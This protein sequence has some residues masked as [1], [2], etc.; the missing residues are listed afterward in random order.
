MAKATSSRTENNDESSD[1]DLLYVGKRHPEEA[2][3]EDKK[4]ILDLGLNFPEEQRVAV[5]S[6]SIA[7][8]IAESLP[9]EVMDEVLKHLIIS[10]STDMK[11]PSIDASSPSRNEN[12]LLNKNAKNIAL[13]A[14]GSTIFTS[15]F[16]WIILFA[17]KYFSVGASSLNVDCGTTNIP[18]QID[19]Y[20]Y[21]CPYPY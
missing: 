17:F 1:K 8:K 9:K 18:L 15:I 19:P 20:Y 11:S 3:V 5:V 12:I 13:V 10:S 2:S 6:A 21:R 4:G 7:A 14:S 16:I